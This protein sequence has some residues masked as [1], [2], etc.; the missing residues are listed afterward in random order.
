MPEKK[1]P[2]QKPSRRRPAGSQ[3]IVILDELQLSQLEEIR[4]ELTERDAVHVNKSE[5]IR[6][7][8]AFAWQ[9]MLT[10]RFG[11]IQQ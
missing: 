6:R 4:A 10:K 7:C 2:T 8:I 1:K 3:T 9:K 11:Q 5:A